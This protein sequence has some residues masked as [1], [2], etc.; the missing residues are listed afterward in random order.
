MLIRKP[1]TLQILNLGQKGTFGAGDQQQCGLAGDGIG[2][3]E[4]QVSQERQGGSQLISDAADQES[5]ASDNGLGEVKEGDGDLVEEEI[6]DWVEVGLGVGG[7]ELRVHVEDAAEGRAANAEGG[8]AALDGD[9][10]GEWGGAEVWVQLEGL[11][12][13]DIEALEVYDFLA[14]EEACVGVGKRRFGEGS[15]GGAW[16]F[17]GF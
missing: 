10:G 15:E 2:S 17:G 8:K 1:Q 5:G 6:E 7:E 3:D 14:E 9:E 16:G 4:A 12:G 11:V 13:V